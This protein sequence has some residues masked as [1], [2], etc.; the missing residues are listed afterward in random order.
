VEYYDDVLS[1]KLKR[2]V[3]GAIKR[4]SLEKDHPP[5]TYEAFIEELDEGDSFTASMF[6][7]LVKELAE[8][9]VRH[10]PYS[11]HLISSQTA[12][13]LRSLA[14]QA[15]VYLDR[16]RYARPAGSSHFLSEYLS[17]AP[18]E[19]AF[20]EDDD[21]LTVL[22]GVGPG[23]ARINHEL[24]EAY[25]G[26]V[27]EDLFP[28][29]F[30][31]SDTNTAAS[32]VGDDAS[33]RTLP[34]PVWSPPP[35]IRGRIGVPPNA[36]TL[37][38]QNPIH[39][40]S[41]RSSAPDFSDFTARRRLAAREGH[42]MVMEAVTRTESVRSPPP[43]TSIATRR[44]FY[45]RR[46]IRRLDPT[47]TVIPTSTLDIAEN[48]S[49]AGSSTSHIDGSERI[50]RPRPVSTASWAEPPLEQPSSSAHTT[51]IRYSRLRRG[52]LRPPE[53]QPTFLMDPPVG[54]RSRT[55]Q[56]GE[57]ATVTEA[58]DD[59]RADS[60]RFPVTFQNTDPF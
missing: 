24:Y 27:L 53:M 41:F 40:G 56:G 52:G 19:N 9:R 20:D 17:G 55:E 59:S 11:K 2:L 44:P 21:G 22:D 57:R 37:R 16:E 54:S 23:E 46:P 26:P 14:A 39:R 3:S 60:L 4:S 18:D 45:L 48:G 35:P 5:I 7:L 51:S 49:D 58:E 31:N 29:W 1:A 30:R 25:V 47:T 32:T 13:G 12:S 8:R 33:E 34:E 36:P 38:R 10:N 15:R 42:D 43:S 28:Q 50:R 6:D